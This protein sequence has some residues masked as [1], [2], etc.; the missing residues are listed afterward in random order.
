VTGGE[1]HFSFPATIDG[2][3]VIELEAAKQQLATLEVEP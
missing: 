3:F 2:R 1:V